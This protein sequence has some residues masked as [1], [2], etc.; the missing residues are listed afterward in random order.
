MLNKK[1]VSMAE[2]KWFG[3]SL[4]QTLRKYNISNSCKHPGKSRK[5]KKNAEGKGPKY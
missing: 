2:E 5:D 1:E 4:L 3:S